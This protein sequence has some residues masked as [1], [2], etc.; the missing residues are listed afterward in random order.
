MNHKP[1]TLS[2]F[3]LATDYWLLATPQTLAGGIYIGLLHSPV[4][5]KDGRIITTAVT[6]LDLHDLARLSRT[7]G[8][9]GFYVIQPLALQMKLVEKLRS[10]WLEGRGGEYNVTRK[11]AF[12]TLRLVKTL[13]E[14]VA[15]IEAEAGGRPRVVF[16]SAKP[17]PGAAGYAELGSKMRA[18]GTWLVVFGTGW[19]IAPEFFE[20]ADHTLLPIETGTGYNHLSVRMAAAIILDRLLGPR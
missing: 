11:E 18:G 3:L 1:Q 4:L 13:D 14:A 12:E 10:Y 20:R 19:G 8:V 9:K 2:F 16:T 15:G 17:R 5:D 7:Y 6:N